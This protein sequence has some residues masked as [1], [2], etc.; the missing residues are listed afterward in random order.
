MKEFPMHGRRRKVPNKMKAGILML[1][2]GD[3]IVPTIY[4]RLTFEEL[5]GITLQV[6]N[7][8]NIPIEQIDEVL[9]EFVHIITHTNYTPEKPEEVSLEDRLLEA[10]NTVVGVRTEPFEESRT[11]SGS[12]QAA[13][14]FLEISMDSNKA[15]RI[16]EYL[17][18][19][20]WVDSY[21]TIYAREDRD[22]L[23]KRNDA[24][25]NG[26][27]EWNGLKELTVLPETELER[28]DWRQKVFTTIKENP[29]ITVELITEWLGD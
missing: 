2:C 7:L 9:C 11:L 20:E 19:F 27:T 5:T 17:Q 4:E 24:T 18:G 6:A 21:L 22:I 28:I 25:R 1:G 13:R 12:I 3:R 10:W 14:N 16:I 8:G 23:K 26:T 15:S 29:E